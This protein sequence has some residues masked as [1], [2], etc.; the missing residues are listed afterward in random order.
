MKEIASS[1]QQPK[2]LDR[3]PWTLASLEDRPVSTHEMKERYGYDLHELRK[4]YKKL[5]PSQKIDLRVTR[6]NKHDEPIPTQRVFDPADYSQLYDS[7]IDAVHY[8][9]DLLMSA[10]ATVDGLEKTWGQIKIRDLHVLIGG[11]EKA[12]QYFASCGIRTT[13]ALQEQTLRQ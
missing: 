1:K 11:P 4:A 8:L 6:V 12:Q 2:T 5:S 10:D 3:T 7:V 9:N 13:P